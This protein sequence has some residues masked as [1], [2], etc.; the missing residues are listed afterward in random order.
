MSSP[1]RH[2]TI[3]NVPPSARVA[4]DGSARADDEVEH[5]AGAEGD[6]GRPRAH[7]ALADERRLLVAGD[8]ARSAVPR[9]A[10]W[11]RPAPRRSRRSWA[12]PPA[13]CAA[14]RASVVSQRVADGSSRPVTAALVGSVTWARPS[15]RF[16]TIQESTVPTHRSRAAP[17]VVGV[18]QVGDLGGRQVGGQAE[19][20]GPAARGSR[21]RCAGPASRGP[22]RPG[23]RS[24]GPRPRS[25]PAGW[26]CRHRRRVRRRRSADR[27]TSRAA[28]AMAV[29]SNSTRPGAG[30]VG[31]HLAS[32]LAVDGAVGA[33]HRSPARRSCRRR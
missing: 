27:A 1:R 4:S 18:E 14:C 25:T 29:A 8:A 16:Q 30:R 10:R 28:S 5:A 31:Q 13:G 2:A 7:A 24:R 23:C 6:L 17:G 12:S 32:V 3:G 33:H 19:A 21:R 11:P 22:G 9:A 20:L 15:V 26:R